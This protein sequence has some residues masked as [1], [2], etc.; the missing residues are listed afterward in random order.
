VPVEGQTENETNFFSHF[1][2]RPTGWW[3]Y[4]KAT[5]RLTTSSLLASMSWN[6]T[7]HLKTNPVRKSRNISAEGGRNAH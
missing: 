5:G 4:G 6:W 7:D 1:W 3:I 2:F